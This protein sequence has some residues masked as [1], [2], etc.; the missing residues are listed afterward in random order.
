MSAKKRTYKF[1]WLDHLHYMGRSSWRVD[2]R[3]PKP[4]ESVATSLLWFPLFLL[5]VFKSTSAEAA[6]FFI[7][8]LIAVAFG[9]EWL[10]GKYRFTPEREKAYF[11]RYPG[12]KQ[13]S[14]KTLFWIPVAMFLTSLTLWGFVF[15]QIIGVSDKKPNHSIETVGNRTAPNKIIEQQD[16]FQVLDEVV[17][18]HMDTLD[19]K[20]LR[21]INQCE[22]SIHYGKPVYVMHITG[23]D[24]G[25][26][27]RVKLL[28][29]TTFEEINDGSSKFIECTWIIG[30]NAEGIASDY[31]TCW[32]EQSD[33]CLFFCDSLKWEN[34]W[35]F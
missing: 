16:E 13:Y 11:R 6:L 2:T 31:Q 7:A 27:F 5:I 33:G 23:N 21:I 14:R 9:S 8:C 4:L 15:Y 32:Y 26:E 28:N 1:N 3:W 12:R 34:G 22:Y 29:H 35:E 30:K 20:L 19:E 10:F 17:G 25:G 24:M 18:V